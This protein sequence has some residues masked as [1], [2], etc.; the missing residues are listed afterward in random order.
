MELPDLAVLKV[1]LRDEGRT[2]LLRFD[3]GKANEMGS[4]ALADLAKLAAF[5]EAPDGPRA[6]VTWSERTTSKGSPIFVSGAD[7]TEREGWSPQRVKEHVR[8]QRQVLTS[9][10]HA[11][12]FHIGVVNGLALGWGTEYLLTCDWRIACDGASFGLPETGL[13]ILPGA[14]G[15]SELWTHVG[16]PQALRLGMTGERI[17]ADEALRIGLVQERVPDVAAGLARAAVLA[18]M[19]SRRS[20]TAVAAFKEA[21]LAS[22]GRPP[23]LRLEEEARA[24]EHCVDSGEAAIGR[25]HFKEVVAGATPP[26]GPRRSWQPLN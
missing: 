16:V 18:E 24:Y 14:G 26:W 20:P 10:R 5:L 21:T 12:V 2:A 19:V 17:G 6:L 22:V 4:A 13:G 23:S 7:V 15:T 8:G 9:L 25:A 1:S 3:H 11:P